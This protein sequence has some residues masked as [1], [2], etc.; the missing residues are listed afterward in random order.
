MNLV[1]KER[2]SALQVAARRGKEE[3]VDYLVQKGADINYVS[4]E[5]IRIMIIFYF[6]DMNALDYAILYTNYNICKKLMNLGCEPKQIDFYNK[7]KDAK[8]PFNYD[9]EK[10][11]DYLKRGVPFSECPSFILNLPE[12]TY[13]DPVN[14]PR[15][16]WGDFIKRVANFEDAPL[17]SKFRIFLF[18]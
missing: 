10:M 3:A 6:Q 4:Y 5:S 14:D 12:K 18:S 13:R 15:E 9:Y 11:I 8:L 7:V 16:T 1:I 2:L 17:V